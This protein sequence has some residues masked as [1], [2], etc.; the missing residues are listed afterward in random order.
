VPLATGE[1]ARV[2]VLNCRL[3]PR[4]R[5]GE[6]LLWILLLAVFWRLCPPLR[7]R[8]ERRNLWIHALRQAGFVGEIHAG[9]SF[10]D[11]Y[12]LRRFAVGLVPDAIAILLGKPPVFLPQTYGPFS[13]ALARAGA[14]AILRAADR[15]TLIS[16]ASIYFV[17]INCA[18][19]LVASKASWRSMV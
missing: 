11:I 17:L 18:T 6:H 3:S 16:P 10:S 7:R 5:L 14:R 12:G 19:G 4:A 13:S 8:L 1:T 15:R 2:R 9:D